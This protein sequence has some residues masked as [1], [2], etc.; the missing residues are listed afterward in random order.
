MFAELEKEKAFEYFWLKAVIGI[1]IGI[2][3]IVYRYI[4]TVA[5][6]RG[7]LCRRKAVAGE[8]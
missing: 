2:L 7:G 6:E 1:V 3:S 4:C 8:E 5:E